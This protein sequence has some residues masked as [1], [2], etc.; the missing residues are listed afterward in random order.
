MNDTPP[1]QTAG[2]EVVVTRLLDAPRDLVFKAWI[3]PDQV[4]QWWG[5]GG[6]DIP[7]ERVEID[8]RVGGRYHMVMVAP[9]GKEYPVRQEILELDE[10]GLIVLR[11]EAMPELGLPEPILTRIELQDDGGKT[12]MTVSGGPYTEGMAPNAESGWDASF[13]SLAALLAR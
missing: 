13:D 10:P 6:F 9:G 5:P 8:P 1:A 11:H 2:R 4:A 12:R 7:R 3:D